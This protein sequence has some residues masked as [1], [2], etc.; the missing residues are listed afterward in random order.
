MS[1]PYTEEQWR[2]IEDVIERTLNDVAD[3]R[4]EIL[5][6]KELDRETRLKLHAI[7]WL[8]HQMRNEGK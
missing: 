1:V 6:N 2:K 4:E 3:R 7:G 5:T 8:W